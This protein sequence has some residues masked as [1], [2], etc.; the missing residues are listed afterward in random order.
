MSHRVAG[1]DLKF[2]GRTSWKAELRF[3]SQKLDVV[4]VTLARG[5]RKGSSPQEVFLEVWYRDADGLKSRQADPNSFVVALA[6]AKDDRVSPPEF[7]SFV[8]LFR[9]IST[10]LL[11]SETSIET[12][13]FERVRAPDLASA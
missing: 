7:D 11:L 1:F 4:P 3:Q 6:R 12:R 9:V 13:I 10:G 5:R 2:T 8:G